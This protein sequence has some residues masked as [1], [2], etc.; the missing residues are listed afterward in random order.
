MS[1]THSLTYSL[2]HSLTHS[3]PLRT[4][5][6]AVCA[7][8]STTSVCS[9]YEGRMLGARREAMGSSDVYRMLREL[10]PAITMASESGITKLPDGHHVTWPA[11]DEW[12]PEWA[13]SSMLIDV[14]STIQ[15]FPALEGAFKDMALRGVGPM[16]HEVTGLAHG[17]IRKAT[18]ESIVLSGGATFLPGYVEALQSA[19]CLNSQG[20]LGYRQ[21]RLRI[22]TPSER[23]FSDWIGASI[24]GSLRYWCPLKKDQWDECGPAAVHRLVGGMADEGSLQACTSYFVDL[25]EKNFNCCEPELEG[26]PINTNLAP[27]ATQAAT[28]SKHHYSFDPLWCQQVRLPKDLTLTLTLT[29]TLINCSIPVLTL[30]VK[31]EDFF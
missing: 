5:A 21:D 16:V 26:R 15:R 10:N 7:G 30:T 11:D 14:P 31:H 17:E 23:L 6:I 3:L 22:V 20:S 29:L 12:K 13:P 2:T 25:H 9:V 8:H 18:R 4:S 1:L 24:L 27:L 28:F 19:L